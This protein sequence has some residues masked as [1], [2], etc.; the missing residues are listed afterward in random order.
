MVHNLLLIP[1]LAILYIFK[2]T[3]ILF[4]PYILRPFQLSEIL[5]IKNPLSITMLQSRGYKENS[6]HHVIHFLPLNS[7]SHQVSGQQQM[8]T[9][10]L[11][12]GKKKSNFQSSLQESPYSYKKFMVTSVSRRF[13]S[14]LQNHLY[15]SAYSILSFSSPGL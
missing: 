15:S 13:L 3:A 4:S 14:F 5:V 6:L 1:S 11:P 10:S 9:D 12:E 2:S 7:A 8:K